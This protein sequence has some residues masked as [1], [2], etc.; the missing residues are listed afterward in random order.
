MEDWFC[1]FFYFCFSSK[2][3]F[4]SPTHTLPASSFSFHQT[5]SLFSDFFF[6]W[7]C[8]QGGSSCPSFFFFVFPHLGA[9]LVIAL[10]IPFLSISSPLPLSPLISVARRLPQMC[11]KGVG[12]EWERKR[13]GACGRLG[14]GK[15]WKGLVLFLFYLSKSPFFFHPTHPTPSSHPTLVLHPPTLHPSPPSVPTPSPLTKQI[16]SVLFLVP[17]C[18]NHLHPL[19]P[20]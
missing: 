18:A 12:A 9:L 16:L 5:C 15:R 3:P 7:G 2:S 14:G 8:A 20:I 10:Q 1:F 17:A 4:L 6:G 13:C 11:L 19:S